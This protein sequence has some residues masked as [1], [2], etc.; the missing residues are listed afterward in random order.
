MRAGWYGKE[1][2]RR[3]RWL[4]TPA[5]GDVPHRFTP[6]LTRQ[7]HE[8]AAPNGYCLECS[9]AI[10]PWE[11]Q[12]GARTYLFAAREVG[13]ALAR[14]AQGSSYRAAAEAARVHGDRVRATTRRR[15][16]PAPLAPGQ[17][18]R[19]QRRRSRTAAL[20]GQLV[21]NW[22]DVFTAVLAE[23]EL[24]TRWPA[25]LL[26]DSKAFSRGGLGGRRFNVLA[27]AGVEPAQ[28]GRWAS[29][30]KV[31]R[32]EPFARKDTAAWVQ[33]LDSLDGTPQ[34]IVCDADA[35]IRRAIG[36]VFPRDGAPVPE[37]RLSEHHVK[38]SLQEKLPPQVMVNT[39]PIG[40]A[41][42]LALTSAT[43]WGTFVQACEEEHHHGSHPMRLVMN[44]LDDYGD[45]VDAQCATRRPNGTNST[46]PVE[47]VLREVG[48]RIGDRVASYTNRERMSKLLTLM[49]ME[50]R[51]RIDG[52][53]WADRIRERIYL[54]GG[55]AAQQRPHDDRKGTYSLFT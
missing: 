4:C 36:L 43:N 37:H 29:A 32:M 31:W 6:T 19:R 45:L 47:A 11:G 14:V 27:A 28:A 26:V 1:S 10:E 22:V 50:T 7:A 30:P 23:G 17:P 48:N 3:Q 42:D 38:R 53:V 41:F 39:H 15:R 34:V 16:P 9:T 13:D 44:W 18:T 52:R 8:H 21:A 33:F 24:P 25:T 51:G 2:H 55:R 46:G 12:A 20:D 40:H 54:A 35:T 49:T 5:N